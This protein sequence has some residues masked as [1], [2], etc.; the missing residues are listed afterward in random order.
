M[1]ITTQTTQTEQRVFAG[2]RLETRAETV[3]GH[4]FL[5]GR[6]VPYDKPADIGWFLEEH[7]AGSFAKSIKEAA[8][9][10]P[11]LL[12]H[13]SRAFPIGRADEWDDNA[14]GLDG[15]WKLDGSQEAQRAAQ[16]ADDEMLSYMSVG[17][18]PI[19]SQWTFVEEWNPEL[20][21]EGKDSVRRLESRLLEVSLVSTPAFK[22]AA[23]KLVRSHDHGR[24]HPG[25]GKR[26]RDAWRKEI[27][28]LR[29]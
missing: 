10:L 21:P 20:G 28:G 17:F 5:H 8:R 22:E 14:E 9:G 4:Q 18:S 13:D 3:N 7:T 23:V 26:Q 12:F 6:A 29:R 2:L 11:L 24:E 27:E 15:I 19:R 25:E 16:L 1:T